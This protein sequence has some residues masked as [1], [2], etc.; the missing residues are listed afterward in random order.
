M[1][2]FNE[3]SY[4]F[5]TIVYFCSLA[6]C[7][8]LCVEQVKGSLPVSDLSSYFF[9]MYNTCSFG[10]VNSFKFQQDFIA[11]W[12]VAVF[13]AERSRVR[14]HTC[15]LTVYTTF[16]LTLNQNECLFGA[17]GFG[18][19]FA[20]LLH[21]VQLVASVHLAVFLEKAFWLIE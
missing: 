13:K 14:T 8:L 2:S 11:Q 5:F 9:F 17:T 3:M 10:V 6:V 21:F 15:A 19:S 16:W 18:L 12:F 20:L 1:Y 7:R 4:H